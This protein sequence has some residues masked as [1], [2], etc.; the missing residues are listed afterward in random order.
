MRSA[1]NNWDF[2]TLLLERAHQITIVMSD[3]GI[4]KSYRH[5]HGFGSHTFSFINAQDERFWVK[6]HLVTQQGIE[7]P[8][9]PGS[10]RTGRLRPREHAVRPA[11][12]HRQRR[13][14]ALESEDPG[15]AEKDAATYHLNLF[16]RPR[17]GRTPTIR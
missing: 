16:D 10:R 8:D 13:I 12:R 3:R 14:S 7:N 6:F 11:E 17:S 9:G 15:H 2:W 4:P 5:M 1:E